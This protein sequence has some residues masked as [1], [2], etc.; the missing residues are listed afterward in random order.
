MPCATY[1]YVFLFVRLA[2]LHTETH[3]IQHTQLY[4]FLLHVT[5]RDT[6]L[7]ALFGTSTISE[8]PCVFTTVTL[9]VMPTRPFGSV[10]LSHERLEVP[11]PANY[12]SFDIISQ[13]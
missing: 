4:Y 1:E 10:A 8:Q 9:P 13:K 7:G 6:F 3:K 12:Y 5:S 2:Y 11:I